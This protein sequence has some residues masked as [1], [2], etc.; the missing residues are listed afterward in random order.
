MS[1]STVESV[2]TCQVS[3]NAWAYLPVC[4]MGA[5]SLKG[6]KDWPFKPSWNRIPSK[7]QKCRLIGLLVCSQHLLW[8]QLQHHA[9]F[10]QCIPLWWR[11]RRPHSKSLLWS[12]LSDLVRTW[13]WEQ[14]SGLMAADH[15]TFR[16][17]I[18]CYVSQV[19]HMHAKNC[20]LGYYPLAPPSVI[21]WGQS[22]A[23][24]TY[25][26]V[27]LDPLFHVDWLRCNMI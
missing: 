11:G 10:G 18:M 4:H 20:P 14:L 22:T 9:V 24:S 5:P 13:S 27:C 3:T 1:T 26:L 16:M 23:R 8:L 2:W 21:V 12:C 6:E 17:P 15:H 25:S 19:F 7:A